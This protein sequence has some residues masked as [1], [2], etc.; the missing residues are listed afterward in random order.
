LNQD[1]KNATGTHEY[2]LTP[3]GY[4]VWAN[5]TG[6][7]EV[8]L[9]ENIVDAS[10][11]HEKQWTG[12]KWKVWANYT[13]SGVTP[14]FLFQ[15]ILNASGTHEYA[16]TPSGYN[17]WA[18]YTGNASGNKTKWLP[19]DTGKDVVMPA[20]M[21]VGIVSPMVLLAVKRRRRGQ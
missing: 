5:Y 2:A 13:G 14:I 1:I 11:T 12:T 20:L 8:D 19:L 15:N 16:L 7:N 10:G 21:G 3:S 18:N 17:V 6:L 9:F 4:E